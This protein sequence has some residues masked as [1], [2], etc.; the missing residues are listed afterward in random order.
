MHI[1]VENYTID[2]FKKSAS[3][4]IPSSSGLT[5]DPAQKRGYAISKLNI[6]IYRTHTDIT[7]SHFG[8]V[9]A[10]ECH[11]TSRPPNTCSTR[12]RMHV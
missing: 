12:N 9:I 1:S 2:S 6:Y 3:I 5:L 11:H 7:R 4:E 8:F 10:T